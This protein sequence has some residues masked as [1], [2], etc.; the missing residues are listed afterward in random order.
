VNKLEYCDPIARI[1]CT[2]NQITQKWI[3]IQ[4]PTESTKKNVSVD[5]GGK[6]EESEKKRSLQRKETHRRG[7]T[8]FVLLLNL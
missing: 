3:G 8:P 4:Q 1:E 5:G 2:C 7:V 6:E